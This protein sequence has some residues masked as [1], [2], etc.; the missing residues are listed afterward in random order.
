MGGL[1]VALRL[2]D[3]VEVI[4]PIPY[5]QGSISASLIAETAA[6]ASKGI[7]ILS[8]YVLSDIDRE[9]L[10]TLQREIKSLLS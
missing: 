9:T 2:T 5:R 6:V 4:N 3:K 10:Q 1:T 7:T 8:F